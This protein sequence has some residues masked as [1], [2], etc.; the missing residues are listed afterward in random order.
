MKKDKK[1]VGGQIKFVLLKDI[2]KNITGYCVKDSKVKQ[3]LEKF[4][5]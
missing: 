2:G 1:S 4:L 3:E 5:A